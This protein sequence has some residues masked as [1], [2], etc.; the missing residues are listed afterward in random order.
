MNKRFIKYF[1]ALPLLGMLS[2]CSDSEVSE[3]SQNANNAINFA[4]TTSKQSSSDSRATI[5][6]N[7][8][9][10]VDGSS[11]GLYAYSHSADWVKGTAPSTTPNF[12]NNQEVKYD[13]SSWKYD[14]LKFWTD[15]KISFFGYL[16]YATSKLLDGITDAAV[17]ASAEANAM[18]QVEFQQTMD[19]AKMIDFVASHAINKKSGDGIVTLDFKHVLTRLNFKARLDEEL[20]NN[21]TTHV[22]VTGLK[23]CGTKGY[24]DPADETGA[25]LIG[26]DASRFFKK[27]T[28]VLGDGNGTQDPTDQTGATY[29]NDAEGQWKYVAGTNPTINAAAPQDDALDIAGIMPLTDHTLTSTTD[30]TKT[31]T[32]HGKEVEQNGDVTPLLTTDGAKQ[33]YLFLIPPYGIE[34]I[35]SEKDVI[36]ELKYVV[37]TQDEKLDEKFTPIPT[38][39]KTVAVSLPNGTLQQG[40]AYNIIFTVGLNPVRVDVNVSDWDKDETTK[41][42]PSEKS[43]T[44]SNTDILTA[45]EALNTK[46]ALTKTANY[47]VINVDEMPQTTP[48]D[49]RTKV[50]GNRFSAFEVGD[51]VELKFADD[52]DGNTFDDTKKVLVPNGWYYE[53]R[54]V[55]GKTRHII[56]KL[57]NYI[58]VVPTTDYDPST[59]YNATD[60]NALLTQLNTAHTGDIHYYAVD[61][62]CKAPAASS[63]DLSTLTGLENTLKDFDFDRDYLYIV[64]NEDNGGGTQTYAVPDGWELTAV[65]SFPGKYLLKPKGTGSNTSATSM[66]VGET[67][68]ANGGSFQLSK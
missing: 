57:S 46:K 22:Y 11:F 4:V 50:D 68:Y 12:M 28:F 31:V 3:G 7:D 48:L 26:N 20:L 24:T 25:T 61:F 59:Q 18:P 45:W 15:D 60:L 17:T 64:F 9:V 38:K 36:V 10:R 35:K 43:N 66:A 32:T 39:E 54:P 47:F 33:H 40:K 58:T 14:P 37:V 56:S 1:W 16:P 52:E 27:A 8:A 29:L 53:N 13:G 44:N 19:A 5:V 67:V 49:L 23:I 62:Y 51:Q 55:N 21:S 30:Q 63:F 6:D 2:G 65:K 34:G 41:Y 42:A